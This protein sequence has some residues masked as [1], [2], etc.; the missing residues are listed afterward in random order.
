MKA[1]RQQKEP[2][3]AD[4]IQSKRERTKLSFADNRQQMSI[5]VKT[6]NA[7]Q[8]SSKNVIQK[9]DPENKELPV[10]EILTHGS[11]FNPFLIDRKNPGRGNKDKPDSPA[12]LAEDDE[13]FSVHATLAMQ[14]YKSILSP[15]PLYVHIYKPTNVINLSSWD[16]WQYVPEYIYRKETKDV[17]GQNIDKDKRGI[18][19]IEV[20][21]IKKYSALSTIDESEKKAIVY[22]R[23]NERKMST[24]TIEAANRIKPHISGNDGYHIAHDLVLGKPEDILFDSGLGKLGSSDIKTFSVQRDS[25]NTLLEVLD[26]TPKVKYRYNPSNIRSFVKV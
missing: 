19:S 23:L 8:R 6:I 11:A 5:I 10:G 21:A 26:D 18:D 20:E 3:Q 9:R 13:A 7:I 1:E 17:S 12:W 4:P 24:N 22:A 25:S 16:Y 2:Q 15:K 14:D